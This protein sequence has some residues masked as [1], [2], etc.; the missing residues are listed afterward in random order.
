MSNTML[1]SQPI[2][3]PRLALMLAALA[4]LLAVPAA[5][6]TGSPSVFTWENYKGTSQWHVRVT[7]DDTACG[8]QMP[9]TTSSDITIQHDLQHATMGDLGHGAVSG[10]MA[11]NTLH[12]SGRTIDDP[13]GSSVLSA[14]DVTFASDCS[15]FSARYRWDYTSQY[16]Q[17]SGTTSY[18]GTRTGASSCPGPLPDQTTTPPTGPTQEEIDAQ[19]QAA[20]SDFRQVRDLYYEARLLNA[21]GYSSE[22]MQSQYQQ[23]KR[24][25]EALEPGVEQRYKDILK[26]DPGNFWAN[27]DM[28]E[29]RK[30]QGDA[31]GY[32][33][34]LS[35][36]V[37]DNPEIYERTRQELEKQAMQDMG[38]TK[39]PDKASSQTMNRLISETDGWSTG[40]IGDI[41]VTK[42]DNP[43]LWRIIFP[44]SISQRVTGLL[45]RAAGFN[46]A[47]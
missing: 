10:T 43:S 30:T 1:F 13:P 45:D 47:E 14:F 16:Q 21:P 12:I 36:A 24:E 26:A 44:T 18:R 2:R 6:V 41:M 37:D 15:S 8:A 11:G 27:W 9:T 35:K 32:L 19:L 34:Y 22:L 23:D 28:G 39:M 3:M 40:N 33:D 4:L 42:P 31:T 7:L 29:L 17:C 20:N 38:L 5:Q 25:I 46:K